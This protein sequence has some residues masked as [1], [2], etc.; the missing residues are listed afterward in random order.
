MIMVVELIVSQIGRGQRSRSGY[1]E[2]DYNSPTKIQF[3]TIYTACP[4]KMSP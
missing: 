2:M 4:E 3:R 1:N